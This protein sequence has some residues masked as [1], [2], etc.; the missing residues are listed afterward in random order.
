[1]PSVSRESGQFEDHGP[2][3]ERFAEFE[4]YNVSFVTFKEAI[5]G[6]PM[7]KGLPD[8]RCQCPHWGYVLKGKVTFSF[9]EGDEIYEAGDAFYAPPGHIP[10]HEAG[11]EYL[12]FSPADQ[13]HETAETIMKNMQAQQD[14][15]A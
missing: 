10:S 15:G 3:E 7:L 8:D 1:M 4:G 9:A 13:L 5:D 2:V 11:S 6:A 12:Q 14:A